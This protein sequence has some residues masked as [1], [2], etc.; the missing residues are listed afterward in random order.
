MEVP[1]GFPKSYRFGVESEDVTMHQD[2]GMRDLAGKWDDCV[3]IYGSMYSY[4]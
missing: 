3:T 1:G 4:E 2:I